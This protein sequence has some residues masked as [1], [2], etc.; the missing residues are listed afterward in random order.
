MYAIDTFLKIETNRLDYFRRHQ[1]DMRVAAYRKDY[2]ENVAIREDCGVGS[3]CILPSSFMGGRWVKQAYQCDDTKG[4]VRKLFHL[5]GVTRN[6]AGVKTG[7]PTT[8][9]I[10]TGM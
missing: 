10:A 3:S 4:F 5:L 9:S 1:E 2:H 6:I 8:S 7:E